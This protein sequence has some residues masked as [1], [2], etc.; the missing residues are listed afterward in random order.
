MTF[1]II[2]SGIRRSGKSTLLNQLK[3]KYQ[4]YY[5]NFDDDRLVHFRIE[6]F[7]ILYEI[8]LELFGEKDYF[9]FDEIQNIEG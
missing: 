7:Q 1:V 5:L 3:E 8:F 2:I 9:Y 6:D 4:G